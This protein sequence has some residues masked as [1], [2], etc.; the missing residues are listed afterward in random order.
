MQAA[1]GAMFPLRGMSGK[2]IPER[3]AILPSDLQPDWE[4]AVRTQINVLLEGSSSQIDGVLEALKP[5]LREP[6]C[7]FRPADGASMPQAREGTLILLDAARLDAAQQ[8]ALV[9]WLDDFDSRPPVRIV[10]TSA[11]PLFPLV[12]SSAFLSEL[13]YRLNAVLIKTP[14]PEEST[15]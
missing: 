7:E 14:G 13:Y 11:E 1:P 10:S 9:R 4:L 2:E 15:R 6:V 5:H 3:P 12:R 8:A